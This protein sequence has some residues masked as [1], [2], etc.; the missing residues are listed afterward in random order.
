[1]VNPNASWSVNGIGEH[2]NLFVRAFMTKTNLLL[3]IS[4]PVLISC[5]TITADLC[6]EFITLP[7]ATRILTRQVKNPAIDLSGGDCAMQEIIA[8]QESGAQGSTMKPFTESPTLAVLCGPSH[9]GKTTF[10]TRLSKSAEKFTVISPDHARSQLCVGFQDSRHESTVWAIYES[11]KCKALR[12]GRDVVLDACHITEKARWHALRGPNEGH[13]KICVVFDVP[14]RTVRERCLR[15]KRVALKEV[16]R[17][18]QAFQHNKPS[19][20]EL[21]LQGFDDAYYIDECPNGNLRS[22]LR[23][24]SK[25][26]RIGTARA[27]CSVPGI[28]C[29]SIMLHYLRI[30]PVVRPDGKWYSNKEVNYG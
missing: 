27:R 16:R 17:M 23:R 5:S 28:G 20:N 18:W 3:S 26:G 24:P 6:A 12:T 10:A 13:R 21:R 29:H 1:M 4:L 9:A 15:A 8:E 30:G 19:R 2:I 22:G 14:W 11:A 25:T 7:N